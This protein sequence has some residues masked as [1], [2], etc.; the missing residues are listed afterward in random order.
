MRCN[1]RCNT[2]SNVRCKMRWNRPDVLALLEPSAFTE[3]N[4]PAMVR[5]SLHPCCLYVYCLC[6]ICCLHGHR[7][8]PA[9]L[10]PTVVSSTASAAISVVYAVCTSEPPHFVSPTFSL[11]LSVFVCRRLLS[12]HSRTPPT[13]RGSTPKGIKGPGK[14]APKGIKAQ[15]HDQRY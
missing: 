14:K 8:S 11:N 10:G 6:C 1:T 7:H 13:E 3:H 2:R 9:T 4:P 12:L 15:G 5:C